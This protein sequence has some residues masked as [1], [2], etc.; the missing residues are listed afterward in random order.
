MQGNSIPRRTNYE[1]GRIWAWSQ[2]VIGAIV[3]LA[4]VCLYVGERW[5][6]VRNA[7]RAGRHCARSLSDLEQQ[8]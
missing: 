6:V 3:F 5:S 1:R 8:P 4:T 2:A 7:H